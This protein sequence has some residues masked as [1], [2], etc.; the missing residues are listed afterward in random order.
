[1]GEFAW[2][3]ESGDGFMVLTVVEGLR[4]FGGGGLRAGFSFPGSSPSFDGARN[5]WGFAGGGGGG[6][7]DFGTEV[8]LCRLDGEDVLWMLGGDPFLC[9]LDGEAVL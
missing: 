8:T 3:W 5:F 7:D 6:V 1:M 2:T 4:G 9:M